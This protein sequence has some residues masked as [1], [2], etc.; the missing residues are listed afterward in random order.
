MSNDIDIDVNN[1]DKPA[2]VKRKGK[3]NPE[4]YKNSP[5]V[6]GKAITA[7][8]GEISQILSN[9][10]EV[11]EWPRIDLEDTAA[12]D[13]RCGQYFQHCVQVGERPSVEGLA[14]A[15]GVSVRTLLD[16]ESQKT[17]TDEHSRIIKKAKDCIQYFLAQIA[18]GNKIYPNVWIFYGKN[19]FGMSDKQDIQI[20]TKQPL[21]ERVSSEEIAERLR[22]AKDIPVDADYTETE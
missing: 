20:S 8:K 11:Y 14:V 3:G 16:W 22:L 6:G 12:I 9:C 13:Q 17:R 2:P 15:V 21:G 10:L 7:T 18:L 5:F 19:W 4:A 1:Q